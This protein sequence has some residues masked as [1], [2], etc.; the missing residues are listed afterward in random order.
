V[1]AVKWLRALLLP[2]IVLLAAAPALGAAL[3]AS[4]AHA[5]FAVASRSGS[6]TISHVRFW[7]ALGNDLNCGIAIHA[8][9]KPATQVLCSGSGIPA[10]KRGAGFGDGGFVFLGARGRA[11]LARLSQDSFESSRPLTLARGRTWSALGVTCKVS[12]T[13]VRCTNRSAHGFTVGKSSYRAF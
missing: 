11:V 2:G 12:A 9:G 6:T 13:A 5:R 4:A 7:Q 10:P 1:N 8:P 3:H